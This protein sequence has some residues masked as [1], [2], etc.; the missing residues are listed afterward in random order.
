MASRSGVRDTRNCSE[1]SL[2]ELRTGGDSAFDEH[3]AQARD[4]L[5]VQGDAR[6]LD[7]FGHQLGTPF[8]CN[9]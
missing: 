5:V 6:N 1:S 4:E 9:S 7:H 2:V 8:E 3:R